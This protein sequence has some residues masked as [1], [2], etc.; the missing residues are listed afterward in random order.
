VSAAAYQTGVVLAAVVPVWL[1]LRHR[2]LG[3]NLPA[4]AGRAV[5]VSG[6]VAVGLLAVMGLQQVEVGRWDGFLLVEAHYGTGLHNPA[7]TF[8]RSA[9]PAPRASSGSLAGQPAPRYQFLL[10][11]GIVLVAVAATVAAEEPTALDLAILVY[12]VIFWV[13]PLVAGGHLAQYRAQLM[14]LPSVVLLRRLPTA[15]PAILAVLAA[16]VAWR[17]AGLFYHY[18]LI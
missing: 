1:L 11:T 7:A 15:V 5:Q 12:T 14:L 18:V 3:L 9:L 2:R 8:L 16:V 17:M 10:V 4:A 13:A 6:L